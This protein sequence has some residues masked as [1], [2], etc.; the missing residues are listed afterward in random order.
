MRTRI[1]A[2]SVLGITMAVATAAS[3]QPLKVKTGLW[4]MTQTVQWT[5]LPPQLDAAMA[6][7]RTHDYQTCVK[8]KD[9]TS[10]PFAGGSDEKCTWTVVSSTGTDMEVRGTGCQMGTEFG[11][12]SEIHGIIHVLDD[13]NGTGSFDIV[14]SHGGQK[15]TGHATYKGKWVGSSCP[16]E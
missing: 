4:Q 12:T 5:G 13:A 8:P 16:A 1:A 2:L 15:I 6:H 9:L 10:N 11:M 14:M 3:L 7:G